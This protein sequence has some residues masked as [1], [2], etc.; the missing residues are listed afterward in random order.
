TCLFFRDL[1]DSFHKSGP[2]RGEELIDF[3]SDPDPSV[4]D[5]L[6]CRTAFLDRLRHCFELVRS[7]GAF[8]RL[9][10]LIRIRSRT[11]RN[12]A[13]LEPNASRTHLGQIFLES[14][15]R[16][17]QTGRYRITHQSSAGLLGLSPTE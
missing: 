10:H 14:S 15:Q 6:P 1:P 3:R 13:L 8:R 5:I 2:T 12:L 9:G 11:V 16:P 4:S 7:V 17:L